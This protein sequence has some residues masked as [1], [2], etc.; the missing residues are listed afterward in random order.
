MF[1][2]RPSNT[3]RDT[4]GRSLPYQEYSVFLLG[5]SRL[6]LSCLSAPYRLLDG[7]DTLWV[8]LSKRDRCLISCLCFCGCFVDASR[9]F[10]CRMLGHHPNIDLLLY[11]IFIGV[12]DGSLSPISC[13]QASCGPRP[14]DGL[15]MMWTGPI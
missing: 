13:I 9:V 11:R 2:T 4:N 1:K 3:K 14:A 6:P 12:D 8:G 10:E 7:V 5:F 15:S